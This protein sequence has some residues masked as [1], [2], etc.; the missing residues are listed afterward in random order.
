MPDDDTHRAR[1][2]LAEAAKAFD[3]QRSPF[4]TD[5]LVEN[6]VTGD[7][8]F[9]LAES[10]ASACRFFAYATAHAKDSD[11]ARQMLAAWLLAE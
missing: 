3:D 1:S 11:A 2:L 5:W 6:H 4:V 8:C 7:E 10:V 9:A